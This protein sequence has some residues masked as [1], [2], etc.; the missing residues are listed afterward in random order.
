MRTNALSVVAGL[1]F[2][3]V[4]SP[5][6][7]GSGQRAVSVR[8][9]QQLSVALARATAGTTISLEPGVYQG[10]VSAAGLAGTADAPIVIEAADQARPPVV[11]GGNEGLKLSRVRHV[12]LRGLV[13]EQQRQN[14]INIDDGGTFDTPS[15][16]VTLG[17][18]T[19]RRVLNPGIAAGIKLTGVQDFVVEDSTIEDWGGGSAI[20]MIG[21]H[22][23]IVRG[24]VFRHRDDAGATGPHIKG[25]STGIVIRGNR[26]EHAGLRAVQIGGATSPQFFRPQPPAAWEASDCIVEHNVFIGSEAVVAFVNVD[27]SVFRHNTVYRPRTWFI[28]ILQEVRAPGLVPSRSGVVSDNLVYVGDG[29]LAGGAVNVGEGTDAGSFTFARNWWYRSD[30]PGASRPSLPSQET[31]GVYGSDPMFV[32]AAAGDFRLGADSRARRFG[33]SPEVLG[34]LLLPRLRP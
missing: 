15:Q 18:L 8:N 1:T 7:A 17:A 31:S 32:D 4:L 20:T 12:T 33:A 23:G 10:G 11:R 21:A 34:A 26:F 14:G 28:R 3:L 30:R 24:N 19:V 5:W 29:D 16:Y 25:G 2:A 6:G 9:S 27:G 22:R 13:F